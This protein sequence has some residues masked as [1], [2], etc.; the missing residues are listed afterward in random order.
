[1]FSGTS[2]GS[3]P[4]AGLVLSG[5]TLYGTAV[6]GGSSGNGTVFALNTDGTGFTFLHSFA[7]F[8]SGEGVNPR[9]G[10]ILSD[11]TLYGTTFIG[12]S[13]GYGTVFK[14]AVGDSELPVLTVPG[15]ITVNATSLAGAVVTFSVTV[16]DNV[17]PN[18][19]ITCSPASGSTFPIRTTHVTCTATD[20]SGNSSIAGFD[21][22]LLGAS[23][24]TAS[25]DSLVQTFNLSH[26]IET[27]LDTKL[28]LAQAAITAVNSGAFSST[29]G[30]LNAFINEVQAQA[31]KKISLSE[32][33][34]LITAAAQIKAVFVCP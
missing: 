18:P 2:D 3:G 21:V 20:A 16:L 29:C 33:S 15:T 32:A 8:P 1:M 6:S 13:G 26:G 28:Q 30:C 7:G 19:T 5:N 31:G 23:Q 9:A 11:N 14:L 10:L 27:S 22:V 34:Q 25:L 24:Q 17:D 12:G 4:N